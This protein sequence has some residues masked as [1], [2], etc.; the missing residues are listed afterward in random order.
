MVGCAAD[1]QTAL[2]ANGYYT[3]VLGAPAD[4]PP[5]PGPA[6]TVLP[7]GSTEV[8]KKV[9]FL[10]NMLPSRTFYPQSI[11]AS[12]DSGSDPAA[13]MGPYYPTATY[14]SAATFATEGADGCFAEVR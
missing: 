3:Y 12:Q 8:A 4:L 10:R 7:W 1:F 14:C 6:I 5:N 2:D 9:L 13:T 11:Q